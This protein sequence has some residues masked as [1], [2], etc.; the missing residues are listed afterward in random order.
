M[1]RILAILSPL[2][3]VF[4]ACGEQTV[5]FQMDDFRTAVL[6]SN[7]A[8]MRVRGSIATDRVNDASIEIVYDAATDAELF[9]FDI[10]GDPD[11]L[12]E[13]ISIGDELYMRGNVNGDSSGW[14][15]AIAGDVSA[16]RISAIGNPA[17]LLLDREVFEQAGWAYID[18]VPCGRSTCFHLR[19]QADVG[20]DLYLSNP[21]YIPVELILTAEQ[22][23]PP[24][25]I[26][27][28][29]DWA[30]PLEISVPED[31]V[32]L[33]GEEMSSVMGNYF[34]AISLSLGN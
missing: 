26:F 13:F 22:A 31:Y 10:N 30:E 3:M 18:D 2:L 9:V 19:G 23:D 25:V 32:E 1:P 11:V 6:D 34:N 29:K 21:G 24:Q 4:A 28:V 16:P 8:A 17:E 12:L 20:L 33:L 7:P 14:V 15:K 5:Q 27:E